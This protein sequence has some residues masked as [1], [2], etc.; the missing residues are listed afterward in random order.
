MPDLGIT[1]SQIY[2]K[3]IVSLAADEDYFNYLMSSAT[4]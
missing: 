4:G 1:C 2:F 3:I